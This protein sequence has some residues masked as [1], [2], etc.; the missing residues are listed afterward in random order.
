METPNFHSLSKGNPEL[1][2]QLKKCPMIN[3]IKCLFC[4]KKANVYRCVMITVKIDF[5]FSV[6]MAIDVSCACLKPNWLSAVHRYLL[7][8]NRMTCTSTLERAVAIAIGLSSTE[9]MYSTEF[10]FIQQVLLLLHEVFI[11]M[12]LLPITTHTYIYIYIHRVQ[13][14][15]PRLTKETRNELSTHAS[16]YRNSYLIELNV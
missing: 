5:C 3:S 4:I 1:Q 13:S 2:Q 15:G 14:H 10:I 12:C 9:M 7:S 8:R 16:P 11:I 6:K